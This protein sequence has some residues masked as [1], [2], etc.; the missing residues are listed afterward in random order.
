M[1]ATLVLALRPRFSKTARSRP[2]LREAGRDGS[3]VGGPP[4]I[5]GRRLADD[6][7]EGPAECPETCEAH[8]ETDLGHAAVGLPEQEHRS[9]DSAALQVAMRRLAERG[10]KGPDEVRLRDVGDPCQGRDVKRLRVVAVHRVARAQHAAVGLFDGSAH[11]TFS[12][13]ALW[14]AR[15]GAGPLLRRLLLGRR[16]DQRAG[17]LKTIPITTLLWDSALRSAWRGARGLLRAADPPTDT[18]QL[19]P[20]AFCAA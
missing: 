4:P 2:R 5:G 13:L 16:R 14:R 20:C 8:V 11:L 17:E 18:A 9:L 1:G 15:P 6:V 3:E 12:R 7:G 10:A 19:P